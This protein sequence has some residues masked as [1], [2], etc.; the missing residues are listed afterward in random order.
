VYIAGDSTVRLDADVPTGNQIIRVTQGS[1]ITTIT[2]DLDGN[3]T[4]VDDGGSG[5]P[6]HF[7]GVPNGAIYSSGHISSLS[8]TIANNYENGS[9]VL[10]RNMWTITTDVAASKDITITDNLKY[11]TEP[12]STKPPDDPCNLRAPTLGLVADD[13]VLASSCPNEQTIDGV[14][15]ADGSFYNADWNG[16]KKNNL[17]IVGGVIQRKRGPVGTFN[18][19]NVH[20]TGYN[21]DYRYDPRMVD[22]PPPFFPTTGQYDVKSWQYK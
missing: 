17:H 7:T 19:N 22:Y 10:R 13:I 16:R 2:V 1:K 11:Q 14:L 8:G 5:G 6:Q 15:L 18:S 21:K 20:A 4:T 9:D 12:D 3:T